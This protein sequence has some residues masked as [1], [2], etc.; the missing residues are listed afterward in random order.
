MERIK[1]RIL[2]KK[3]KKIKKPLLGSDY[4][5]SSVFKS[6]DDLKVNKSVNFKVKF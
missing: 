6:H 4:R 5:N 3:I 2:K 1:S